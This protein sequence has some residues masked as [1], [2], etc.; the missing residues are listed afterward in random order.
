MG[1]VSFVPYL[2]KK[3]KSDK[4]GFIVLIIVKDGVSMSRS[5]GVKI[6]E[7]L[8][9][10]ENNTIETMLRVNRSKMSIEDREDI[11]EKY[12]TL[13]NHW[14]SYY[15]ELSKHGIQPPK[16]NR[17][18]FLDYLKG[19]IVSLKERKKIG[20]S[21][22]Y[23]TT[24]YHIEKYLSKKE[25]K[26]T[27]LFSEITS[28]FVDK[29][30]TY[31]LSNNLIENTTKNYLNTIKRLYYKGLGEGVF[32][33]TLNPFINFK[34][35]R[36][37][38][39]KDFLPRKHLECIMLSQF[40]RQDKL[41]NIKNYFLFQFFGQGL[42]VSDLLTLRW[43][44]LNEGVFDFVQYKTRKPHKIYLSPNVI[45][46][47]KD[48][49]D[50]DEIRTIVERKNV[51]SFQEKKYQ[52]T[53]K[54]ITTFYNTE[55]KKGFFNKKYSFDVVEEY[56]NIL[57][58]VL[59]N[60]CVSILVYLHNYSLSHKKDFVFPLITKPRLYDN[61]DFNTSRTLTEEQY[62]HLQTRTTMYNKDLKKLQVEV[63]KQSKER[64]KEM[65]VYSPIEIPLTSHLPRHTFT[66]LMVEDEGDLHVIKN[67]IGHE[68][69]QTTDKYI[70]LLGGR[71][72]NKN[73]D[74]N[75]GFTSFIL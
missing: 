56:K 22:R 40:D 7:S 21:K 3:V 35:R 33:T 61:V 10:P 42:R 8:W 9:N 29:F 11:I 26:T 62:N 17:D 46:I 36:Q 45:W 51:F 25:G 19:H 44:N 57:D 32:T 13:Q 15:N 64:G 37:I 47:I 69:L 39:R 23:T 73:T 48:Y 72:E 59:N 74:F 60:L 20:T 5:T 28:S 4:K 50:S 31:L 38:V 16:E 53:F 30:E 2:K 65:G 12:K 68:N 54:E 24:L 27:L 1:K 55:I 52:N 66:N 63:N 6:D 18:S 43:G 71:V 70:S 41:W 14:V 75:R 34:N 58:T 67:L 49:V